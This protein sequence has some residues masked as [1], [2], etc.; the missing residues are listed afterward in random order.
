M[1]KTITSAYAG[2]PQIFLKPNLSGYEGSVRRG[3]QTAADLLTHLDPRLGRS[4]DF[5]GGSLER[6]MVRACRLTAW[7]TDRVPRLGVISL[8]LGLLLTVSGVRAGKN[9]EPAETRHQPKLLLSST[10][11]FGFAPLTVQLV[12]TLTGVEPKDPNYCHPA[13]T[14]VRVDPGAS[15]EKE[16]RVT[17]AP[18][19]VHPDEEVSVVT[20][21][22]KSFELAYAG[23]YLYRVSLIGKDGKEIRSNYVTVKVLRVP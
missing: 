15:P 1:R 22:S 3:G 16:T 12:A 21:F 9:P 8:L 5:R 17:E 4:V 7:A 11:S 6:M 20:T 18:R 10:P 2:F 14:W 13:I 23:S 19:C